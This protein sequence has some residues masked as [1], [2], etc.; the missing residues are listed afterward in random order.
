MYTFE[1][2]P[3]KSSCGWTSINRLLLEMW[4][5]RDI[6]TFYEPGLYDHRQ[7]EA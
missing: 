3:R 5:G 1:P 2:E 4:S 7:Q 6:L